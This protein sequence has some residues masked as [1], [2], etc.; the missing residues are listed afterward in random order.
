MM[1][2]S[3][4]NVDLILDFTMQAN[5]EKAF[6][7]RVSGLYQSL[8][9]GKTW[10]SSYPDLEDGESLTTT[11]VL[12]VQDHLFAA[13]P[14]GV[15]VS[16]DAGDHWQLTEL[17]FPAPTIN[18]IK[19]SPNFETDGIA[20]ACSMQDGIYRTEDFGASWLP[21]NIGLIDARMVDLAFSP[22]FSIDRTV[23]AASETMLYK[24]VNQGRSWEVVK[25]W[26]G[27]SSL[28][29]LAFISNG[30]SGRFLVAGTEDDGLFK[31]VD[32]KEW[33]PFGLE[34]SHISAVYQEPIIEGLIMVTNEQV[35]RQMKDVG[36]W[37]QIVREDAEP[38]CGISASMLFKNVN[39][40]FELWLGNSQGNIEVIKID[41]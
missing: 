28:S 3:D 18:R 33:E 22:Q 11:A 32:L 23:F 5:R 26:Q 34:G 17:G 1:M 29:C 30:Q 2:Y 27:K 41:K 24:S 36:S 31:S 40:I 35:F 39:G 12:A 14:G 9:D 4:M 15:L 38:D 21:W 19:S 8:D 20:I 10:K 7:A 37:Q 25:S 13:I 6:C 16:I